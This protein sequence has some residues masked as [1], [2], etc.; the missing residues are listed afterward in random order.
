MGSEKR[1]RLRYERSERNKQNKK[2]TK[3]RP[4]GKPTEWNKSIITSGT[5]RFTI[6]VPD[7]ACDHSELADICAGIGAVD[8][9]SSIIGHWSLRFACINEAYEAFFM[10]VMGLLYSIREDDIESVNLGE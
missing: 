4:K 1:Q 9:Q 5:Y 10:G 2:E 8:F 6:T 7:V 3:S